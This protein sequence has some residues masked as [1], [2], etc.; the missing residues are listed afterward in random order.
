MK[1]PVLFIV[2]CSVLLV[3]CATKFYVSVDSISAPEASLKKKYIL[4]PGLKDIEPSDLQ[5]KEYAGYVEKALTSMGFART[6]SIEDANVAIFV[7][8]GIGDPQEHQY[9]YSLPVWG[10][11]GIS[12]ST[13]YGTLSTYGGY[14]SY[15]GT[16]TYTPKYGITGYTTHTGNYTT[17]FRFFILDAVDLEEYKRSQKVVQ[18]WQTTVTSTG[19]SGDLRRV[20][21]VLVAAA[22]PYIGANTGKQV[23]VTLTENDKA[24]VEI[25]GL[26][27]QKK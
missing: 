6:D 5:F 11:T 2:M 24:V 27:E 22:K 20:F 19:S 23:E 10:Q 1:R 16:T 8:Y 18:L 12:S 3:G 4:L 26:T 17:Y 9:I 14:G 25:R 21:P 15:Y 13:T 7:V